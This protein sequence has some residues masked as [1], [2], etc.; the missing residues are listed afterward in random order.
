MYN[1]CFLAPLLEAVV[2]PQLVPGSELHKPMHIEILFA[3]LGVYKGVS[4]QGFESVF[5]FGCRR[6]MMRF[7]SAASV[8]ETSTVRSSRNSPSRTFLSRT[9]APCSR[10]SLAKS[11]VR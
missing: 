1:E 10:K 3:G 6:A 5:K 11:V 9:T 4:K 7:F 8:T 2:Q